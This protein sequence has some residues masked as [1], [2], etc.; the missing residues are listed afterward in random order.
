MPGTGF[1][2][3]LAFQAHWLFRRAG[4][5]GALAF[6][7]HWLFRRTGF[8]GGLVVQAAGLSGHQVRAHCGAVWVAS[9]CAVVG[10]TF[11][12]ASAVG[13]LGWLGTHFQDDPLPIRTPIVC[14]VLFVVTTTLSVVLNAQVLAARG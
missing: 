9:L 12:M 8:S 11:F 14:T 13:W 1:S 5:S 4:F 3:A 7:A 6:Q 2:G 10:A